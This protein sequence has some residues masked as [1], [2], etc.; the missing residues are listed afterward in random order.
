MTRSLHF[1][2][3]HDFSLRH[4]CYQVEK[5]LEMPATH[6]KISEHALMFQGIFFAE[7]NVC[8]RFISSVLFADRLPCNT[9]CRGYYCM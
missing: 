3:I 8:F 7:Y 4:F 6:K 5:N 2:F 9:V 1:I